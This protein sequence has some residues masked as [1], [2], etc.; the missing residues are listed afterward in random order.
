[1]NSQDLVNGFQCLCNAGFEGSLC[2][3]ETK[4]CLSQPCMNG[5]SCIELNHAYKCKCARGFN[6]SNCEVCGFLF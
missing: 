5:G 1:M 4:K 3:I 2:E 6:G